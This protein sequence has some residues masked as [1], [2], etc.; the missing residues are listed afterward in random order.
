DSI[1][2]HLHFVSKQLRIQWS[3]GPS[4]CTP[5]GVTFSLGDIIMRSLLLLGTVLLLMGA[6]LYGCSS[7]S[8]DDT[9]GELKT[10][11]PINNN[12]PEAKSAQTAPADPSIIYPG[13]VMK[14]G[15]KG[16]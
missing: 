7:K 2:S 15:K 8:D 6:G 4:H 14:K 16:P 5:D 9:K 13:Q 11:A 12:A 3:M 10:A 1:C